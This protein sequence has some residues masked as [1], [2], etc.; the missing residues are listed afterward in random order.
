MELKKRSLAA[1]I[2][3]WFDAY[4]GNADEG[5]TGTRRFDWTRLLPFAALHL[6]CLGVIWTGV[7]A[8]AVLVAVALY[9]VRMFAITAFYHRYFSHKTFSTSRPMQFLFALIGASSAQRGPLW[10]ACQ[11]RHHHQHSDDAHDAHSPRRRGFW[12][13]HVGWITSARNF[14]TDY[15]RVKDLAKFPELVFLN[16][17]DTLLPVLLAAALFFLGGFLHSHFPALGVTG[18]QLLVWGFFISTTLLI[19]AYPTLIPRGG[20][21]RIVKDFAEQLLQ[22]DGKK[23]KELGLPVQERKRLLNFIDK[24]LRGYKHDGRP[25]QHAWKGWRAPSFDGSQ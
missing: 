16:R 11:H 13:A 3:R 9:A 1:S 4:A 7:S 18:G 21:S 8:V 24:Y 6:G 15:S 14:P 5:V 12:W 22:T 23:L 2:A 19:N 10:W 25:G 20:I 17:F